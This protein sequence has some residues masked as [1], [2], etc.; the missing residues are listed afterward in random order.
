MRKAA[1]DLDANPCPKS[2]DAYTAAM[3]NLE[4][5]YNEKIDNDVANMVYQNDIILKRKINRIKLDAASELEL[6]IDDIKRTSPAAKNLMSSQKTNYPES[7]HAFQVQD[8]E[9]E[10]PKKTK[11]KREEWVSLHEDRDGE[12]RGCLL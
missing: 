11:R 8:E 7:D 6:I 2:R 9:I 3:N 12:W 10:T 4:S 1:F 5:V